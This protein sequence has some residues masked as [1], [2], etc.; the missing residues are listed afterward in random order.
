[1]KDTAIFLADGFEEIEGLMVV[2]LLRRV[3]IKVDMVSISDSLT[4]TGSHNIAVSADKLIKDIDFEAYELL[5]LP[6]GM[7][8]TTRLGE[9]EVLCNQIVKA[10]EKGKK[11]AAICA[12][13]TVFGK[14][15][16]LKE[17]SACCYPDME[18]GLLGAKVSFED[19]TVDGN[20][21]TSRGLGTALPFALALIEQLFDKKTADDLAKKVVYR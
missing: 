21:T 16:I 15:G 7:P 18:E 4:V 11:L 9:C 5:V 10:S 13:P 14:L 19:V 17:K 8:G 20:I 6:G 1:M 3:G 12:A 2:D